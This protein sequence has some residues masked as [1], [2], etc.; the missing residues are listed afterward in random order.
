MG[1]QM[2]S[3]GCARRPDGQPSSRSGLRLSRGRR[4]RFLPVVAALVVA[5]VAAACSSTATAIAAPQGLPSWYSVPLPLPT[6]GPGTLI[7]SEKVSDSSLDG[8]VYRV[9]YMSESVLNKPVVVTGLV[10][11]PRTPAPAG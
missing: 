7:K 6:A 10:I 3:N 1:D 8:T 11:V 4:S 5:I 9:M 2:D